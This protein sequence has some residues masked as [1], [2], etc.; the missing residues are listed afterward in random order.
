MEQEY[1]CM[2]QRGLGDV[3]GDCCCLCSSCR[4]LPM[5]ASA[6]GYNN[7]KFGHFPIRQQK[8]NERVGGIKPDNGARFQRPLRA[9]G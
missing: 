6:L 8:G 9:Q 5:M 4:F 2:E 7:L 1:H 3:L